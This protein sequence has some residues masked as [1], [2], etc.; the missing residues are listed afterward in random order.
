MSAD[1]YRRQVAQIRDKISRLSIDKCKAAAKAEQARKK[2]LDAENAAAR[3]LSASTKTSKAREAQRHHADECRA[4]DALRRL[5]NKIQAEGKKLRSAEKSLSA[6]EI[7]EA[8]KQQTAQRRAG[9]EHDRVMGHIQHSLNR[10]AH[11]HEETAKELDRL[12]ALPEEIVV[13]FFASDPGSNNENKLA[14]DE[15][16]RLIGIQIRA[17][18]HRDAVKCGFR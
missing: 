9:L 7:T 2:A 17:S 12:K 13:A 1:Y 10:H 11:L 15:E 8:R 4:Q 16:A 5:E 3:S 18:K 6:A 14:L